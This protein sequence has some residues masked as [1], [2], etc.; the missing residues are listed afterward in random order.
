MKLKIYLKKR[1]LFTQ[2]NCLFLSIL[3]CFAGLCSSYSNLLG[4]PF[5]E[6][7]T[8]LVVTLSKEQVNGITKLKGAVSPNGDYALLCTGI[9][10]SK[11]EVNLIK[12]DLK[13][14]S[15]S[16]HTLTYP[17]SMNM[18]SR[19]TVGKIIWDNERW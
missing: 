15:S 8:A 10:H 17:K 3:V 4:Q 11:R 16:L 13:T 19:N 7:D 2:Y 6:L 12:L 1:I 18:D 14:Y 9:S 5:F